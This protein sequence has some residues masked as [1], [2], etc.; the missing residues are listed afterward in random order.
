MTRLGPRLF[1]LVTVA[2]VGITVAYDIL[3]LQRERQ[4]QRRR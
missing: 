1:L 4:G 3:R 2:I